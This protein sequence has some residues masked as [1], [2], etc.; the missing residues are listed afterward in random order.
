MK[1]I[2]ELLPK[3]LYANNKKGQKK[4]EMFRLRILNTLSCISS[5]GVHQTLWNYLG[6]CR[7]P[8][9]DRKFINMKN[10]FHLSRL[11][12]T[13]AKKSYLGLRLR[14]ES[15]M[16]NPPELDVKGVNFFKSTA[17]KKTTN[18][19][20]DKILMDQLLQSEDGNIRTARI[21]RAI[22]EYQDNMVDEIKSGDMGYLKR[23]IKVK[24]PDAYKDPMRIGQYKAVYVWNQICKEKDRIELP[25]TVTLVK[26]KL[27]KK[28]DCAPLDQ[29]P[30]IY[31]KIMRLFETDIEIGGG[32]DSDGKRIAPKGIKAI[33]LPTEMDEVPDWLLS[34]IDVETLI[35]DNMKLF[36][37]L[38]RPLGLVCGETSHNGSSIS[39]Y[40]N[41]VKI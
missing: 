29:W 9:E 25:A 4:Y 17:S 14:Q 28:S 3:T 32:V 19:I 20:Y 41:V 8:E 10:E 38:Y 16:L 30:D 37:Q 5:A 23:S 21:H 26:V 36:T 24:S 2:E 27:A 22:Q 11:L 13:Y 40:T 35:G 1:Y 15:V 6:H 39:Y 33:A 34:I 12:I 31:D 7:V 18:F